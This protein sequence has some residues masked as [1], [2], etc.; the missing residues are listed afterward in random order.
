MTATLTRLFGF[1]HYELAEDMVQE[2]IYQALKE[3]SFH[4]I[5]ENPTG[6]LYK[7]AK[8]KAIDYLRR[9]KRRM[10]ISRELKPLLQSGYT[11]QPLVH[12][13]FSD[14]E[15]ADSQLRMMF[16]SCHPSIPEEA[17][18]ALI[19]KTLCG[20]S[21]DE[22]ARAFLSNKDSIEKRLYRAKEKIREEDISL[23]VPGEKEL[24]SRLQVVLHSIYLLFNEGYNSSTADSIIRKDLCYEAMRLCILLID[25]AITNAPDARA[26]L[27]L[28]C[29]NTSRFDARI[30]HHQF[31]VLLKDQ[32]RSKWNKE[33]IEK[34]HY[35]LDS[36]SEGTVVSRYHLEAAI[37]SIHCLAESFE[38]TDW[39]KILSL[40]DV[41]LERFPSPIIQL[42]RAIAL[43]QTGRKQKAIEEIQNITSLQKH[44]LYHSAL[45]ELHAETGEKGK[46]KAFFENAIELTNSPQ[47]KELLR[48]KMAYV[49]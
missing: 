44:Y 36:A 39:K 13:F 35:Y 14:T 42:N 40:Y 23:D 7:V 3:W 46:A 4:G 28:M 32:D 8:N 21:I 27:A 24:S 34:G 16:A 45:G 48:K 33:L 18:I 15:I 2:T 26:L 49:I 20:F 9:E 1:Q 10:E 31:I 6:W 43:A 47:E 25:N 41:L 29:Y 38:Q 37:S 12:Q 22:I 5:P 30:D 11:M 17:Q 19:L